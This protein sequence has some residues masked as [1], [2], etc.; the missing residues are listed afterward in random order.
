MISIGLL[1]AA[2]AGYD[3][4][5]AIE[6]WE[7]VRHVG[8]DPAKPTEFLVAHPDYETR[9]R[10]LEKWLEESLPYYQQT[11]AA[12]SAQLPVLEQIERPPKIERAPKGN[13]KADDP[14]AQQALPQSPPLQNVVPPG[15]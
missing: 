3:P 12:P 8:G 11:T 1:L 6:V 14:K 15:S 4:A 9:R 7:R 2:K 5:I 13:P 10:N